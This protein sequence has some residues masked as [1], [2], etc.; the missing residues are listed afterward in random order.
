MNVLVLSY[1]NVVIELL[2][3]V[4]KEKNIKS[5]NV[6]SIHD[7]SSNSYDLIFI[8]DSIPKYEL[9]IQELVD[10]FSYSN[11]IFIGNLN[12]KLQNLVDFTIKKPFLPKDINEIINNTK[13]DTN[14]KKIKTKILDAQ[15]INKIKALMQIEEIDNN[16]DIFKKL[17]N[18][19]DIALKKKEAKEFL[20]ECSNISPK[21]LKK[22]LKGAKVS[23]KIK[24]KSS[25]NE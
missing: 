17:E 23:I 14:N 5:E 18:K 1:S 22:L 12:N 10:N 16:E 11:L 19:E 13:I 25:E 21:K 2:K 4:F 9:Q 24:Y 3:L 8:D 7:T 20:I 15:E 6:K